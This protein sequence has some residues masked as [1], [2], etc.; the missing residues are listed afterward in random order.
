MALICKRLKKYIYKKCFY[1]IFPQLYCLILSDLLLQKKN[2]S[3]YILINNFIARQK[4]RRRP[5]YF[6][7]LIRGVR[8]PKKKN[9]P[10]NIIF[11]N[12]YIQ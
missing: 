12:T 8:H 2:H 5:I 3:V 9:E 11:L 4:F 1:K 7:I 10:N 6:Y